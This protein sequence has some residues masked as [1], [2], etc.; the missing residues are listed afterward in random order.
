MRYRLLIFSIILTL[1]SCINKRIIHKSYSEKS[2]EHELM[3]ILKSD[4]TFLFLCKGCMSWDSISGNWSI[5]KNKLILNSF[6]SLQDT[7]S[8]LEDRFCDTCHEGINIKVI[9]FET[10]VDM[11]YASISAFNRGVLISEATT[12]ENGIATFKRQ[13]IDSIKV[14]YFGYNSLTF[15]PGNDNKKLFIINMKLEK[16]N[17]Y[18]MTNEVWRIKKNKVVSPVGL[19]LI[20]TNNLS[21]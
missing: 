3:L 8:Y 9:D 4:S 1:S 13:D 20:K 6:L 18:V 7:K 14:D 12:N 10:K 15:M 21:K 5:S 17:R 2:F 16:L 19:V 11:Q